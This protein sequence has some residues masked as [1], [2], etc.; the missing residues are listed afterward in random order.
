[1]DKKLP[2]LVENPKTSIMVKGNK[3]SHTVDS[4]V[5]DFHLMRGG[6]DMSKL[7][8]RKAH[9]IRPFEEVGGIE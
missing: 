8:L 9:D 4:L 2:K 1:M 7:L 5:R 3:M 6:N